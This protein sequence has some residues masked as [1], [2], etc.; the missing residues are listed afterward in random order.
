MFKRISE[1]FNKNTLNQNNFLRKYSKLS[2][3]SPSGTFDDIF[4]AEV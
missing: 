1:N 4:S 2:V 3:F